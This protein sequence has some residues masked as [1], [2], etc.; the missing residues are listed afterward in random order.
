MVVASSENAQV[1]SGS[2]SSGVGRLRVSSSQSVSR[3]GSLSNIVSTL[4]SNNE[5]LMADSGI[6]SG[7]GSFEQIGEETGVNGWLLVGEV[8][9]GAEGRFRREVVCKDFGLEAIGNS[10]LKLD[11]GVEDV[12]GSPCLGQGK[13]W[14]RSANARQ[15][16]LNEMPYLR[17]CRSI[18]PRAGYNP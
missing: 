5:T 13:T 16:G 14:I 6:E 1:V 8:E 3:N 12:G 9:L 17:P 4:S 10:V 18:C 7:D 2:D 11:L 15:G